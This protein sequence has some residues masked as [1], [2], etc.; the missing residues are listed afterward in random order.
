MGQN[1]TPN[2]TP[3]E[4]VS[5]VPGQVANSA[6]PR[7]RK[8]RQPRGKVEQLALPGLLPSGDENQQ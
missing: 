4:L 8:P 7:K 6:T 5:Q 3:F 1:D 2:Q